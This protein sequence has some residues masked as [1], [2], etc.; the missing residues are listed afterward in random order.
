MLLSERDADVLRLVYWCQCIRPELLRD[1]SSAPE[2]NELTGRGFIKL[3]EKSGAYVTTAK[4]AEFLEAVL[5]GKLP[6]FSRSYHAGNMERRLR[7]SALAMTAYRAGLDLFTCSP[8]ELERTGTLFLTAHGRG[9]GQNP[10][11]STRVAAVAHIG[12]LA[13]GFHFIYPGIGKLALTDELV[14]FNNSTA[15]IG[16]ARRCLLFAGESY[17]SVTEELAREPLPEK[18]SKLVNYREA[19]RCLKLPVHLLSCDSAGSMQLKIMSVPDYRTRLI[20]AALMAHYR[21]PPPDAPFWDALF[22]GVPLTLAADMDLRRAEAGIGAAKRAGTPSMGL[23]ALRE[24]AD[25]FLYDRYGSDP[26]VRIYCLSAK[27]LEEFFQAP[28]ALYTPAR[29]QYLTT[30]GS[31][32]DTPFIQNFRAA[33]R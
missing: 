4:G 7:L 31:V 17:R 23:L 32:V 29:T 18:E 14:A 3:H 25:A 8:S 22:D 24:Q 5:D 12:D 15:H 16:G 10:W 6:R 13:C 33:G 30:K 1:I 2:L 26:F 28:P 21:P 20:R 19:Y 9:R 11:G 27:A